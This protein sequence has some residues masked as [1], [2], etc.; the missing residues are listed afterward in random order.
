MSISTHERRRLHKKAR[1][2]L[3]KAQALLNSAYEAHKE[4]A[5]GKRVSSAG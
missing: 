1:A 5:Y 3:V 4:L 2:N